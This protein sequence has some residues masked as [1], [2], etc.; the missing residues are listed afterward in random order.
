MK[1]SVVMA[2]YN[3][4]AFLNEQLDSI[5]KQTLMPDEIL[6]CDDCSSDNTWSILESYQ[7]RYPELIHIYSNRK[8]IGYE[9]NFLNLIKKVS[10]DITFLSDQDDIWYPYKIERMYQV[11]EQNANILTLSAAYDLID[12]EGE[13]FHDIRNIKF[14]NNKKLKKIDWK[15]FVIHPRYPGMSMAVRQPIVM[16]LSEIDLVKTPAHDWLLNLIAAMRD[17]M[18]LYD[19]VLTSYRQHKYNSI[20]SSANR[21]IAS[22]KEMR[23]SVMKNLLNTYESFLEIAEKQVYDMK[24]NELA[25]CLI[26]VCK[27]RL[28][29]FE[30]EKITSLICWDILNYRYLTMRSF[31]GDLYVGIK[32][33]AEKR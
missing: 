14:K 7:I 29:L 26:K 17:G 23:I 25:K 18:Y 32:I 4:E 24:K 5:L 28:K 15:D 3:G 22:S 1:I 20:G 6:I 2:T 27:K 30:E 11:F 10:G 13:I 12:E 9:K 31:F 33:K 16:Q 8:N 19:N 21:N